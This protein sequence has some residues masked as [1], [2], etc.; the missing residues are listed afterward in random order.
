VYVCV[1]VC[2]LSL[3]C[4]LAA[5]SVET[6]EVLQTPIETDSSRRSHTHISKWT[7]NNNILNNNA[8][9]VKNNSTWKSYWEADSGSGGQIQGMFITVFWNASH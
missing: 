4:D 1:C 6:A 3:W 2:E 5:Y 8:D 7:S 9:K